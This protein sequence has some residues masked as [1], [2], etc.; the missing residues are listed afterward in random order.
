MAEL[1]VEPM[2]AADLDAVMEIE[3]CSFA[4]PWTSGL[5][6][7]E[8]TVEFSRQVVARHRRGGP[9]VGYACWWVVAGEVHVLTVAVHPRRRMRGIGRALVRH[10]LDD[11]AAAG[12]RVAGLEVRAD[13]RAAIAMYTA[14]GFAAVGERRDYYG[15]GLHAVLMDCALP[16][17]VSNDRGAGVA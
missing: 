2:R 9:I 1:I 17:A 8:M 14:C 15:A 13:N 7:H 12:A 16:P 3:R 11:G 6:L 5:F 4:S 10:L